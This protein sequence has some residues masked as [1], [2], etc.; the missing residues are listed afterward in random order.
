MNFQKLK[1]VIFLGCFISAVPGTAQEDVVQKLNDGKRY[2]WEAKFD[3]AIEYLKAVTET[4]N[5]SKRVLFDAYLHLGFVLTRNDAT[6]QEI[7]GA[8]ENAVRANP[9]MEL[10]ETVIPPDLSER[11]NE[12]RDR[13]VGCLYITTVH[14]NLNIVGIK[15]GT[16]LYNRK[17]PTKIC[18]VADETYELIFTERGYEE[19]FYQLQ[20]TAGVTDTLSVE[21][22]QNVLIGQSPTG[23]GKW[24]WLAGVLGFGRRRCCFICNCHQ[25]W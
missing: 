13:L 12:V 1:L 23:G 8:F 4:P 19:Q 3:Q 6:E 5:V 24:K 11:F 21:L 25:W 10:D 7:N 14:A 17:T 9:R 20:L 2:F 16:V 15:D 22:A 18:E